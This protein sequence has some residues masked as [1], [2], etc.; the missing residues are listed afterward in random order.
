MQDIQLLILSDHAVLT[1]A[2][3]V[4]GLYGAALH[5]EERELLDEFA[6]LAMINIDDSAPAADIPGDSLDTAVRTVIWASHH[7]NDGKTPAVALEVLNGVV[8]DMA[9]PRT[10][11]EQ[12]IFRATNLIAEAFEHFCEITHAVILGKLQSLA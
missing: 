10:H 8:E 4:H 12:E 9:Q 7:M 1:L 2:T 6:T 3:A 5:M 11:H